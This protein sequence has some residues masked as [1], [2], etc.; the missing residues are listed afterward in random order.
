MQLLRTVLKDWVY[1]FSFLPTPGRNEYV[2]VRSGAAFMDQE[3]EPYIED[4]RAKDRENC[5]PW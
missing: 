2:M 5:G 3:V 1:F 4:G